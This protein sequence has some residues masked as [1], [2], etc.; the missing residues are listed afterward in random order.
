LDTTTP[1]AAEPT[2]QAARPH[3]SFKQWL[4]VL[5]PGVITGAAGDDPAGIG[6]YAQAGAQNGTSLLWLM[7]LATPMVQVV[8]VTCSKMGVVTKKGL[9]G[10]LKEQYGLKVA[11]FAAVLTAFANIVTIGADIAGIG[12][13]LELIFHVKWQWFV[14]PITVGIWYFQVYQDY[15]TVRKVFLLLALTL[16]AYI[17]AGFMARPDWGQV[18]RDTFV[19]HIRSD[20]AFFTT[21][22]GLL[23]TTISPY[24]FYFQ[25]ATE[26]DENRSVKKLDDV[27]ID[28]TVGML[29]SNLV[30]YFIILCTAVALHAHGIQNIETA[31]QAAKSLEP[32]AG[33]AAKYIFAAGMIGAGLLAVPVLAAST[34]AMIGETA[35]WRFGLSKS[36]GRAKGF[37]LALSISLFIGVAITLSGINPI[38]ALYYSQIATGMVAPVILFLVFRLASRKDILGDYV[39]SWKQ[40]AIGWFTFA[41]MAVAVCLM[42]YGWIRA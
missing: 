32:F 30:S 3:R 9:S 16:L 27:T 19:P 7:L 10:L 41:L 5:G 42:V 34:A 23:G 31:Q 29:F 13:A 17:I 38:K 6:T 37:Y 8:Q 14:V 21:T 12:A 35:G 36:A 2:Q 39:N 15:S 25:A 40:Q 26:V 1:A 20:V 4:R 11:I 24:M 22:V 33:A 18:L 28:T